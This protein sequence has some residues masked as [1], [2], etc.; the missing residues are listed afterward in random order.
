[1]NWK[2]KLLLFG[3]LITAAVVLVKL[4]SQAGKNIESAA[5]SVAA[6]IVNGEFTEYANG[7][8]KIDPHNFAVSN[9]LRRC[10]QMI[11]PRLEKEWLLPPNNKKLKPELRQCAKRECLKKR[12]KPWK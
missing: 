4:P 11:L 8:I 9:L 12:L 10:L 1:M 6:P 2:I 5:K 7:I 3:V